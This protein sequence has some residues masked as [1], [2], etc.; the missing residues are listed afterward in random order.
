MMGL[1]QMMVLFVLSNIARPFLPTA[2]TLHGALPVQRLEIDSR[3]CA[4]AGGSGSGWGAP[5]RPA[6][7]SAA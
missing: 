1:S 7:A 3:G 2:G 6:R 4:G 5:G